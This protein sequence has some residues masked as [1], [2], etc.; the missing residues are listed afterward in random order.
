MTA[1]VMDFAY[2]HSME[3]LGLTFAQSIKQSEV[4]TWKGVAGRVCAITQAA[5]ARD[6]CL[7]QRVWYVETYVL[8]ML[9]YAAQT[10]PPSDNIISQITTA[11][12]WFI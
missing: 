7:I 5:Y 11:A 10:L 8:S 9:W 6:M 3:I 2:I 4:E 1:R 12:T